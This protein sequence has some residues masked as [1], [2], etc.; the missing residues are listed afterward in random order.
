VLEAPIAKYIAEKGKLPNRA[1]A[2]VLNSSMNKHEISTVIKAIDRKSAG[3]IT[4]YRKQN[5]VRPTVTQKKSDF[6]DFLSSESAE[7]LPKF[8]PTKVLKTNTSKQ[9]ATEKVKAF[10]STSNK[11]NSIKRE[12]TA[13]TRRRE[14]V[15]P[16]KDLDKEL[17]FDSKQVKSSRKAALTEIGS[18]SIRASSGRTSKALGSREAGNP[19]KALVSKA[20]SKAPKAT[21]SKAVYDR[22]NIRGSKSVVTEPRN[23]KPITHKTNNSKNALSKS[24]DSKPLVS[25][26]RTSKSVPSKT[27]PS[28]TVVSKSIPSKGL[29]LSKT[30]PASKAVH[31]KPVPSVIPVRKPRISKAKSPVVKKTLLPKEKPVPKTRKVDSKKQKAVKNKKDLARFQRKIKN[32]F[33]NL[34]TM[35]GKSTARPVK[36]AIK[37]VTRKA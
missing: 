18:K 8:K 22:A 35:F 17:M 12:K 13:F 30:L 20:D 37:K 21:D 36:K 26:S 10:A 4:G 29:H 27:V 33:G 19:S 11:V 1:Q 3:K 7:L 34:E 2:F 24:R 15:K 6:K 5:R 32:D 25:K 16:R 9:T 23:S 14:A 31:S 28:K